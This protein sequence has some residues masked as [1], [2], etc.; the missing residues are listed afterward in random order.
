MGNVVS[1]D[2]H[3]QEKTHRALKKACAMPNC[4]FWVDHI[5]VELNGGW[6]CRHGIYENKEGGFDVFKRTIMFKD[7]NQKVF[8][9]RV[10]RVAQRHDAKQAIEQ[11]VTCMEQDGW[12]WLDEK[13]QPLYNVM[14]E[15]DAMLAKCSYIRNVDGIN[16]WDVLGENVVYGQ[17]ITGGL[18]L[19]VAI[20]PFCTVWVKAF[21]LSGNGVWEVGSSAIRNKLGSVVKIDEARGAVIE[22]VMSGARLSVIDVWYL[23]DKWLTDIG[24]EERHKL[25]HAYDNDNKLNLPIVSG[26]KVRPSAAQGLILRDVK[27][28]LVEKNGNRY[29]VTRKSWEMYVANKYK[30]KL[31]IQNGLSFENVGQI[32]GDYLPDVSYMSFKAAGEGTDALWY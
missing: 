22:I 27:G 32:D 30:S 16:A 26:I 1:I 7:I 8:E 25:I 29:M 31:N 6:L 12:D 10:C 23:H 28:V 2:K 24:R 18:R 13:E 11:S 21:S 14:A 20:D 19:F 5:N 4:V 9:E 17:K 15:A 3:G